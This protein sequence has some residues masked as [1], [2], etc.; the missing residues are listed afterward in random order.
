MTTPRRSRQ[1]RRLTHRINQA[2]HPLD[3]QTRLV[4]E[5]L[6][7][8]PSVHR[9]DDDPLPNLGEIARLRDDIFEVTTP[10]F[11]RRHQL[12]LDTAS[13]HIGLH[14]ADIRE[15]FVTQAAHELRFIGARG[16]DG[17]RKKNFRA[18]ARKLARVF[19]SN[20]T[21]TVWRTTPG[22]RGRVALLPMPSI[23]TAPHAR[24]ANSVRSRTSR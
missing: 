24:G 5:A 4:V 6:E 8:T 15:R 14:I 2:E 21:V 11:G 23:R 9:L 19:I 22:R 18:E 7:I 20:S 13:Y 10:G 12:K 1:Q 16:V 3:M 17:A